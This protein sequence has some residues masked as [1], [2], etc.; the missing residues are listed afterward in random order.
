MTDGILT[1]FYIASEVP[2]GAAVLF[3]LKENGSLTELGRIPMPGPGWTQ[4]ADGRICATVR[5]PEAGEAYAEY[6]ILSGRRVFGPVPSQGV[7]FCHFIRDGED[8]YGANY[9]TGSVLHIRGDRAKLREHRAPEDGELGCD[10]RRQ[11]RPHCHQCILSPDGRF[12]LVCDLGL[13][14]VFVYD[15]D[16]NPVSKAKVPDGHGARHSIFSHDGKKLYTLSEMASTLTVFDWNGEDGTLSPVET[17]SFRPDHPADQLTDAASIVLSADGRH[18]YC[19]NRGTA[20]TIA[21]LML[22]ETGRH[23]RLVS[24]TPSGGN[25]PRAIALVAGDGF[26]VVCNTFSDNLTVFRVDG[27][28]ELE[29]ASEYAIPHPQC[30]NE[31]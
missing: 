26:L 31:V 18:L 22:D 3:G 8:V 7:S 21:H 16:M 14:S 17:V 11:E 19:S 5:D 10:A 12:V 29:K 1:E 27:E 20:N 23:A 25:H 15:R 9:H 13:D 30:V 28:G 4:L 2:A 6:S 24:Q